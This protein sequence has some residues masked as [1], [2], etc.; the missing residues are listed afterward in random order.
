MRVVYSEGTAIETVVPKRNLS[1]ISSPTT[2]TTTTT[3][4]RSHLQSPDVF[5]VLPLHAG[6]DQRHVLREHQPPDL[7]PFVV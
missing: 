1:V 2:T 4:A 5:L 6:P 3:K 7:V